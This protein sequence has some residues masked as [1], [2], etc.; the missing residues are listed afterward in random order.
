M[1]LL[2]SQHWCVY[3]HRRTPLLSLLFLLQKHPAYYTWRTCEMGGEYAVLKGAASWICSKQYSV[4]FSWNS[5][6]KITFRHANWTGNDPNQIV[7]SV[8]PCDTSCWLGYGYIFTISVQ[9]AVFTKIE[10][11]K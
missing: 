6:R 3:V 8:L 5:C 9:K 2:V 7:L 11:N 4:L 10:I 1:F